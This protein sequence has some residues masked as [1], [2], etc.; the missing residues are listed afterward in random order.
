MVLGIAVSLAGI[1]GRECKLELLG[2]FECFALGN[3]LR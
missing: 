3:L 2:L 1:L